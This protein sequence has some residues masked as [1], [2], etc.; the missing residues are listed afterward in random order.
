MIHVLATV[1]V[2]PGKREDFLKEFRKV[3]PDVQREKGCIEYGPTVDM[4]TGIPVPIP[5][6]DDVVVIIE[7]WESLDD[8][9]AHLVAPHMKTYRTAV[10]DLVK[11][12]QIQ[13]LKP[14]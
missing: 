12:M 5:M 14:V 10:K 9:K 1:E 7:R 3:I 8:L 13:V 4:P 2:V 6:R 11:G